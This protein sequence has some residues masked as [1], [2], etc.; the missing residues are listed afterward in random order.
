[1]SAPPNFPKPSGPRGPS[2]PGP[3]LPSL[4]PGARSFAAISPPKGPPTTGEQISVAPNPLAKLDPEIRPDSK[5][6][7]QIILTIDGVPKTFWLGGDTL[8]DANGQEVDVFRTSPAVRLGLPVGQMIAQLLKGAGLD[9]DLPKVVTS[10]RVN[11]LE[12]RQTKPAKT[13]APGG[14]P[15]QKTDVSFGL[16]IELNYGASGGSAMRLWMVLG[17][18]ADQWTFEFKLY[19]G[20]PANPVEVNVKLDDKGNFLASFTQKP[21][22]AKGFSLAEVGRLLS[23]EMERVMGEIHVTPL[24]MAIG[25][26]KGSGNYVLAF[27]LSGSI[28]LSRMPFVGEQLPPGVDLGISDLG[29]V[30]CNPELASNPEAQTVFTQGFKDIELISP[31]AKDNQEDSKAKDN[32]EERKP[33]STGGMFSAEL[34]VPGQPKTSLYLPLQS[35]SQKSAQPT[36]SAQLAAPSQGQSSSEPRQDK[37]KEDVNKPNAAVASSPDP[38]KWFKVGKTVGPLGLERIGLQYVDQKVW[39]LFDASLNAKAV[40]LTI[41]GLGAGLDPFKLLGG[42]FKPAFTLRGLGLTVKGPVEVG[43]AFLR[44]RITD[45]RGDYDQFAGVVL[46]KTQAFTVSGMGSYADPPWSDPSFFAYAFLDKTI[47]GPP[48]FFVT[49]LAVGIAVNC[50]FDLPPIDQVSQF[51]LVR[52]ALGDPLPAI[53]KPST[54]PELPA[55]APPQDDELSKLLQIQQAMRPYTQPKSGQVALAVG[56]RFT[57]FNLLNSFGLL[58]ASF[59]KPFKLD[60]L[61]SSRLQVPATIPG[62]TT[63]PVPPVAQV[64]IDLRG[65]WVPEAGTLLI[66]GR[67]AEGSWFLDSNCRLSGGAAF[68][69]WTKGPHSGDFVLTVGGYHPQFAVP[70]HYPQVPRLAINF[71]RGAIAIKAEAYFAL[72]PT[73]LMVG[74]LIHATYNQGNVGAWFNCEANFLMAW[75]P[76]SYKADLYVE[77]GASYRTA[78]GSVRGAIG[79]QIQLWGPDLAGIATINLRVFKFDIAFGE[80]SGKDKPLEPIK[81]KDFKDRFLPSKN[82]DLISIGVVS[83]LIRTEQ[84]GQDTIFVVNPAEFCIA[85]E[86]VIPQAN[87]NP[88]DEETRIGIGPMG[89]KTL[90]LADGAKVLDYTINREELQFRVDPICKPVP[91]ALWKPAAEADKARLPSLDAQ[92]PVINAEVGYTIKPKQAWKPPAGK[93]DTTSALA[94]QDTPWQGHKPIWTA[95]NPSLHKTDSSLEAIEAAINT[96]AT[97]PPTNLLTTLMGKEPSPVSLTTDWLADLQTLPEIVTLEVSP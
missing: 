17:K 52:L 97:E 27:Q 91:A 85:I 19:L 44:D 39:F 13:N 78:L 10:T 88:Q 41:D 66:E 46:I 86:S 62:E 94:T 20:D 64:G 68:A 11:R 96:M 93:S 22:N 49:G 51:P 30:W 45:P 69:S 84:S 65:T 36:K 12:L 7:V 48:F 47:G 2:P 6:G 76:F 63:P 37:P 56:V 33:L 74:G 29:L 53:P 82:E 26:H 70:A 40:A 32:Q 18:K 57:T 95:P 50:S 4:A 71:N 5:F 81:A 83:G 9:K 61:L 35:P 54:L 1:M 58:V 92:N 77:I 38:A 16:E 60:L 14:D 42:H 72:T 67:I 87:E 55:K 25:I 34:T 73:A 79:A 43:G 75:E 24:M 31:K 89:K 59:G 8:K 21:E 3:S 15:K 28:A 90:T 23:P 80:Q